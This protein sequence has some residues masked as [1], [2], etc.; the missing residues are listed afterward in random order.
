MKHATSMALHTYW[1]SCHRPGAVS[2]KDIETGEIKGCK[3]GAG[4]IRAGEIKAAELAPLLPSLF[5]LDLDFTAGLRFRFCGAA[6]A[7]RFGHDLS[8]EGFLT[9]WTSAD[10]ETLEHHIRAAARRSTGL[11]AGTMAETV[12]GGFTAFEMLVLPLAGETGT[13]G[14]IG[15]MSR[16]GGHEEQNRIRARLLSQSLRSIR[17]LS[18]PGPIGIR[19]PLPTSPSIR[20]APSQIRRQYRHLSV[21]NGGK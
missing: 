5:L 9:L 11:V 17:F 14:L 8:E 4:E 10:R 13:A 1:L 18:S 12:A 20:L 19:Q 21:V 3:I 2:T 16:T 7:R 6:L 15:S